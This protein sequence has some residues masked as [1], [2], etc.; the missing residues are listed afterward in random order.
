MGKRDFVISRIG[1]WVPLGLGITILTYA[2][3]SSLNRFV[4]VEFAVFL[5]ISLVI[6]T[7]IAYAVGVALWKR[8]LKQGRPHDD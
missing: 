5:V 3:H 2:R 6:W 4:S 8:A 1:K 7:L